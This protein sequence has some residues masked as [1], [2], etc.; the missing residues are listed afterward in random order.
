MGILFDV[1]NLIGPGYKEKHYQKTIRN[2]FV[3]EGISFKEQ[4]GVNI[5]KGKY[6]GNYYI[7]FIVENKI[8]LEIKVT[9]RIS[10]NH[11]M[12]VLRYLRET[13][14][15][16]GIIISFSRNDLIYR[17]ILRGFD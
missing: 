10:R 5:N 9:P 14:I 1:H 2:R 15:E 11:V 17:R 3:E 8:V 13:G 6:I 4:V 12:Q 16:L 7:D